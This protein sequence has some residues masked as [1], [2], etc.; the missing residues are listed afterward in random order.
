[1]DPGISGSI[2]DAEEFEPERWETA[3]E[4]FAQVVALG[5]DRAQDLG[6]AIGDFCNDNPALVRGFQAVA[7]GALAGVV[8]ARVFSP[9]KPAPA[10]APVRSGSG[11]ASDLSGI[12][13]EAG[14]TL[15]RAAARNG[16]APAKSSNGQAGSGGRF[17]RFEARHAAQLIPVVITLARNPLV[18]DL[19]FSSAMKAAR[20]RG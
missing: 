16:A 13:I 14:S 18:R 20:R 2:P 9:P 17:P 12:L 5:I 4:D 8:L 11:G 19:L 15:L 3:I 10:R 7:L 1:M 6:D